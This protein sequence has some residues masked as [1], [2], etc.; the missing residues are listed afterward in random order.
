MSWVGLTERRRVRPAINLEQ[1]RCR[2]PPL[3]GKGLTQRRQVHQMSDRI[4]VETNDRHLVRY[5]DVFCFAHL[6]GDGMHIG[7]GDDPRSVLLRRSI[8]P[9]RPCRCPCGYWWPPQG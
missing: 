2:L 9:P 8:A 6:Q 1:D 5:R 3:V 7:G 4:V